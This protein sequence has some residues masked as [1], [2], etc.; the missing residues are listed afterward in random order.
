MSIGGLNAKTGGERT[1]KGILKYLGGGWRWAW[2][3]P[4]LLSY[5]AM[6]NN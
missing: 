3:V 6:A 4:W 2:E 5:A 1:P